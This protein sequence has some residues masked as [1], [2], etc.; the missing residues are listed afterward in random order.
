MKSG[1]IDTSSLCTPPLHKLQTSSHLMVNSFCLL[2]T[3]DVFCLAT[4]KNMPVCHHCV[5]HIGL[6][7]VHN[8]IFVPFKVSAASSDYS[9]LQFYRTLQC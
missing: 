9:S 1:P 5:Y 4:Y 2:D 6:N 3:V 8:K 7:V